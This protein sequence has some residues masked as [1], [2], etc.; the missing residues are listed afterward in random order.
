MQQG[1]RL[2]PKCLGD[3]RMNDYEWLKFL[4][5]VIAIIALG[6]SAGMGIVMEFYGG[7]PVHG[8]FVLR[9]VKRIVTLLVIPGYI[10]MALTGVWLTHLAWSFTLGWIKTALVL[11]AFGGVT[12]VI[13]IVLLQKQ[14][15]LFETD[16]LT[17]ASYKQVSLLGRF[18]GGAS[19][20]II[21]II[22]YLMVTKPTLLW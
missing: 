12:F 2:R 10:L 9:I 3:I 6:T 22:V 1:T 20:F 8:L 21:L 13:S 11:W 14:I 17:S 7:H 18:F 15:A 4:H 5:I 19:G 16:G